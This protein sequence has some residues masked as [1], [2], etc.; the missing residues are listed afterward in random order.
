MLIKMIVGHWLLQRQ[1]Q[2]SLKTNLQYRVKCNAKKIN[3]GTLE[4]IA[5]HHLHLWHIDPVT[6]VA[7]GVV[8]QFQV[9]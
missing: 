3:K 4:N 9:H 7:E 1:L 5:S 2:K 8:N 6:Q